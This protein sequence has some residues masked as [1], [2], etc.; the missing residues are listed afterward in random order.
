LSIEWW[1]L[2]K[3]DVPS[4]LTKTQINQRL[5]KLRNHER[6]YPELQ[7]KY[8]EFKKDYTHLKSELIE[9]QKKYEAIAEAQALRIEELE[10]MVFILSSLA[11]FFLFLS[12]LGDKSP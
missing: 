2:Y 4:K 8:Q 7:N 9:V 6:L 3:R 10:R 12:R 11:Y 5:Q 1:E